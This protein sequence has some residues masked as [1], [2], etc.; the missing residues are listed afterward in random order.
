MKTIQG[1]RAELT[2]HGATVGELLRVWRE[3]RR[4][5][6]LD[7]AITAEVST[8]HLSFVETGRAKPSREMVL[9]LGEHLDVPLRERNHLLLAAGYAPVYR[10]STLDAPELGAAR[11]AVRQVLAGHEPYP[12]VVVDR[13][14]NLVE[15]N[16]SVSLLTAGAAPELLAPVPNVLKIALHPQGMAP[17]VINLGEL[18][19]D[20]LGRLRR[21]VAATADP[22]LAAL[23]DE[24]R[25]Y[26]C[27]QP[28][29]EVEIPSHGNIFVP[30]RVRHGDLELSFFSTIATFGAPLDVTLAELAIESFYPADEATGDYLRQAV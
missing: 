24:V 15:A 29:P 1:P 16:S 13:M 5:S 6:Q 11:D 9:R 18:R 10:E 14:W 30:L 8:R 2:T 26:P 22:E 12:A 19:A 27:D 20:L 21:Q 25:G 7:L 28:V 4:I 17:R 3:R 23:L